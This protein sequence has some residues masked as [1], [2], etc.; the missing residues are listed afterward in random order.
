[1][2]GG[3]PLWYCHACNAEM[4]PIVMTPEPLCASC[5][6]SF[7]E[8]LSSSDTPNEDDPRAFNAMGRLFE[9][10]AGNR[11]HGGE[12]HNIGLAID[13]VGQLLGAV[14]GMRN[15]GPGTP[16]RGSPRSTSPEPRPA[17]SRGSSMNIQSSR[18][19][20]NN[21]GGRSR[22]TGHFMFR[23]NSGSGGGGLFGGFGRRE[24]NRQEPPGLDE[25]LAGLMA[26][27]QGPDTNRGDNAGRPPPM[28][29]NLVMGLLGAGI[30]Q[31]GVGAGSG[32]NGRW[33]DYVLN[34]EAL[35]QIITQLMDANHAAPVPVPEEMISTWPRTILTPDN[36]LEDQDCA[37]CKESFKYEP[38]EP[39]Q[40]QPNDNPEPQEAV[41]L[42]C[43][44]SFHV[45]CIE[46][47][48][49]VKGTCPVCRFE[50]VPQAQRQD[51][52]TPGGSS[53]S[54]RRNSSGNNDG[55]GVQDNNTPGGG[56][57]GSSG[58]GRRNS[59]GNNDGRGGTPMMPG[60]YYELD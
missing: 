39:N 59:S 4:R 5:H 21:E 55:R 43:K 18:E 42:P 46:P 60:A 19:T 20:R 17:T 51:N 2:P 13:P 38:P 7:I 23:S 57:G 22:S 37:V 52:N 9:Q 56:G 47:W 24:E 33:G 26:N 1:M 44:H 36:P 41:T 30:A 3:D 25:L 58:S 35:D 48:V 14:L 15:L 6:S 27:A 28:L 8:Q 50:L 54:G 53:G 32:G 31:P 45:E 29:Q 12:G 40:S 49:K 11:E 16:S 34:Q 10:A